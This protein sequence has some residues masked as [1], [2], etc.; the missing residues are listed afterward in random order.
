MLGDAV[1]CVFTAVELDYGDVAAGNAGEYGEYIAGL[2][3]DVGCGVYCDG[4]CDDCRREFC[5]FQRKWG[6]RDA[7]WGVDG[8]GL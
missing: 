3:G 7:D 1:E 6:E 2:L 5:R 8:A 4:K